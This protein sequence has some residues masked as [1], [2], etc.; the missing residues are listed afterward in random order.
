VMEESGFGGSVA[1]PVAR[2]ILEKIAAGF[3]APVGETFT[4]EGSVD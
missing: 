4:V 1:A 2:R 3:E